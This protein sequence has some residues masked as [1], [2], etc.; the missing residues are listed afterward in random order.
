MP[1]HELVDI[2]GR[3]IQ[4]ENALVKCNSEQVSLTPIHQVQVI[5]VH[6]IRC[7]HDAFRKGGNITLYSSARGGAGRAFAIIQV[8]V[9]DLCC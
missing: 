3:G 5:V 1:Y 4:H 7:I 8:L 2:S 9:E 6:N